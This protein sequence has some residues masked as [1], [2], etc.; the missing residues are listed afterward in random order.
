MLAL[1]PLVRTAPHAPPGFQQRQHKNNKGAIARSRDPGHGPDHS[2]QVFQALGNMLRGILPVA[3][4]NPHEASAALN[5]S[6]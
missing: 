3:R 2:A 1:M 6:C 5:P 4:K